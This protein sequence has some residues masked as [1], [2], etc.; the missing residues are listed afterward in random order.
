MWRSTLA[1]GRL[2]DVA[3]CSATPSSTTPFES[4]PSDL[5]LEVA[6]YLS[7]R[8]ERLQLS[9]TSTHVY[10]KVIPSVYNSL[11]LSG[12]RQCH[13][14]LSML[15]DTSSLARHVKTLEIYPERIPT[16][17]GQRYSNRGEEEHECYASMAA[18]V[19]GVAP[20]MDALQAFA[21]HCNSSSP[22]SVDPMWDTLR[23]CCLN[24]KS[25]TMVSSSVTPAAGIAVPST[26][27]HSHDKLSSF[28]NLTTFALQA[29]ASGVPSTLSEHQ[30][31]M[32]TLRCP[33]LQ[34]LTLDC[35]NIHDPRLLAATWPHLHT[36]TLGPTSADPQ[37]LI[38]FLERHAAIENLS[39]SPLINIDLSLLPKDALPNLK[40][41]TGTVDQLAALS[42]R[43]QP[44]PHGQ[45]QGQAYTGTSRFSLENPQAQF[46]VTNPLARSLE[47][48]TLAGRIVLKQ[49]T[50]F[51][52]YTVLVG[53]TK[54]TELRV[55][56]DVQGEYGD[57]SAVVKTIVAARPGLERLEL[58]C[59]GKA[60]L[61]LETFSKLLH[62][63]KNLRALSLTV[64]QLLVDETLAS[65]AKR[66]ALT[67]PRLTTVDIVYIHPDPHEP[68]SAESLQRKESVLGEFVRAG[69]YTIDHDVRNVPTTLYAVEQLVLPTRTT[70]D[71]NHSSSLER[72]RTT[73][74]LR[75]DAGLRLCS[76]TTTTTTTT[77]TKNRRWSTPVLP[78][79]V[80]AATATK[81][82]DS[83]VSVLSALLLMATVWG[84][85]AI[86]CL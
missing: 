8:G 65:A 12:P 85:V 39:L 81:K 23:R 77:T 67:N 4:L 51:A 72:T 59:V 9:L 79:P 71:L 19:I 25:L 66:F 49:L 55:V 30:L 63:L 68:P 52:M 31:D 76:Q 54:L 78:T 36:L 29:T 48:L 58:T 80:A 3:K 18:L 83:K 44:Q 40:H 74:D 70:R 24:L 60:S 26:L 43:G 35:T 17:F 32:L 75:D 15:R 41:F 21:W 47:S 1:V 13:N 2:E 33:N 16:S 73:Y 50:P 37:T 61:S 82:I 11:K 46:P 28:S 34:S 86:D 62:R 22:R 10:P 53:L 57:P 42:W 7:D 27:L 6:S 84:G 56:F 45:G 14:T 38:L 69:Y 64:V 5:L 20:Y